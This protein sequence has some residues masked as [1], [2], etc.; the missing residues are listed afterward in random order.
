MEMPP[1]A[2]ENGAMPKSARE[3]LLQ[4]VV[5]SLLSAARKL[6]DRKSR[7]NEAWSSVP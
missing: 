5:N 4:S 6:S 2:S 1:S 7:W 3:T